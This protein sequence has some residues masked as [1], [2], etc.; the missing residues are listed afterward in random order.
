MPTGEFMQCSTKNKAH[1]QHS[2]LSGRKLYCCKGVRKADLPAV[3]MTAEKRA[4]VEGLPIV[5]FTTNEVRLILAG[6]SIMG[7]NLNGDRVCIKLATAEELMAEEAEICREYGREPEM[8]REQA[9]KL[10]E[11]IPLD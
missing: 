3:A 10:T 11:R 5:R 4:E 6:V 8:T 2:W 7:E 1:G 9:E